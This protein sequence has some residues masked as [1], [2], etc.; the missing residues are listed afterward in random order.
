VDSEI[1]TLLR[2]DF[3]DFD[4]VAHTNEHS[5]EVQLPLILH[6]YGSKVKIVPISIHS[7]TTGMLDVLA[8]SIYR[9]GNG[10][11]IAIVASS[12]LSHNKS[13]REA[14]STDSA[15][16]RALVKGD[17]KRA[18]QESI[19]SISNVCGIG[20]IVAVV[21]SLKLWGPLRGSLLRYSTSAT[22][23]HDDCNVV[24][25]GSIAFELTQ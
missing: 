19:E 4:P 17:E 14:V 18:W 22:T 9:A 12:D 23:T 7:P 15:F 8:K 21:S 5:I 6:V 11:K 1:A 10:K 2:S 20:P 25:Y 13:R 3:P 16:I 24:G